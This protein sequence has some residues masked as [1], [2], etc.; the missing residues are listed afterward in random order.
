MLISPVTNSVEAPICSAKKAGSWNILLTV[1]PKKKY[2]DLLPEIAIC[3]PNFV[4]VGKVEI[5]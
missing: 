5:G 4:Q 3:Y 2:L 1:L